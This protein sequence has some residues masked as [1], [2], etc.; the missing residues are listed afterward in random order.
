VLVLFLLGLLRERPRLFVL[1]SFVSALV[2][3]AL[4]NIANPD[5]MIVRENVA[6]YQADGKIDAD[7]LSELS[8]DATPDLVAAL[9]LLDDGTRATIEP[10]LE[11]QHRILVA[12]AAKQGWPS[13]QLGRAGAVA[14]IEGAGIA[15]PAARSTS[16]IERP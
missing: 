8:A 13:W 14:A 7:Y 4:L 9:E 2:C 10:A 16:P 6:R 11:E 3:L 5:A 12:A 1:G 15:Q